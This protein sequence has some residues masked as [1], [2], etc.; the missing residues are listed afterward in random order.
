MAPNLKENNV[1]YMYRHILVETV[2]HN[3]VM[4]QQSSSRLHGMT[5]SVRKVGNI[6][7]V[8]VRNPLL[9]RWATIAG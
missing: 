2:S 1:T 6:R 5:R 3:Q 7:F 4:G 9:L 8:T